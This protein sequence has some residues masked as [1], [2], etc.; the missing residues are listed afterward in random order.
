[1]SLLSTGDPIVSPTARAAAGIAAPV[2]P[3][4]FL[5]HEDISVLQSLKSQIR[6]PEWRVEICAS[7]MAFLSCP[8][9]HGPS[10]LV[11]DVALPGLKDLRKQLALDWIGTP[12]ILVRGSGDV[13][14]TVQAGKAGAVAMMTAPM[15]DDLS[16]AITQAIEYSEMALR[17]EQKA[18]ALKGRYDALSAREREVMGLVVSG[19]LNKQVAHELGIS[20]ITVKAHRGNMVRKMGARSVADLVKFAARLQLITW[21]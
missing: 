9:V 5:V 2:P 18:R 19:L 6:V 17:H 1:M 11:V 4:V 10:C 13:V 21:Q 20:E 8:P 14:M 12:L 3:T 16:S 15:A 7:A